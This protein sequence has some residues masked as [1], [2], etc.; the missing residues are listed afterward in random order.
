MTLKSRAA[1]AKILARFSGRKVLVI[2][3]FI[4]DHFVW[5]GVERISP[6]A[7]VPVVDVREESYRL[8][9][10]LNVAANL[11]ALGALPTAVGI[12]GRDGFADEIRRICEGGGVLLADVAVPDRATIRKTRVISGSHQL[13]RIDRELRDPHSPEIQRELARNV[14]ESLKGAEAVVFSDYA[15]GVVSRKLIAT[16]VRIARKF[17]LPIVA[18]PK[19]QNFW[20]YKG[21]TLL[22]PNTKEVGEALGKKLKNEGEIEAGGRLVLRRLGL[23]ALLITRG[24]QGMSLFEKQNRVTHLPT[25]A[26]EVFDV[27]GAGDTV[28]AV[29]GAALAAGVDL[30]AGMEIAN[31]A[32]GVSVGKIGT[33]VC[34]PRE[35]LAAL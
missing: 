17:R 30:R 35:I 6:E 34:T 28:T 29:C 23:K 21:V 31:L 27:T 7:P 26:R 4:L 33:A 11:A 19:L 13:V 16:A 24:E 15:K 32:A 18:D 8:G 12:L 1:A 3:D 9:G 20:S 25:R 5:G 14:E 10:A 2:G 22:T